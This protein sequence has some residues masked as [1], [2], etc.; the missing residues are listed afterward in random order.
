[1]YV[2]KVSQP[3]NKKI[4]LY[5]EIKKMAKK[6]G[7]TKK[8]MYEYI[9]S[10]LASENE[11]VEFCD[12]EIELLERKKNGTNDKVSEKK[13]AEMELVY[14]ALSE[15]TESTPTKLISLY[16]FEEL[17]NENG[18]VTPQ[19]VSAILKKLVDSGRV[20]TYKDKK[21]TVFTVVKPK[22]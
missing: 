13:L 21:T 15:C 12:H 14:E 6:N 22:D 18:I 8:E 19:K 1:M 2:I 11:I 16:A 9:K 7:R 4:N 17:K 3:C 5:K 20:F 10:L